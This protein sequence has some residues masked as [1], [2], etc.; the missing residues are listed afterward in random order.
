ML[1]VLKVLDVLLEQR[2]KVCRHHPVEVDP[3]VGVGEREKTFDPKMVRESANINYKSS[4]SEAV[5]Q[6]LTFFS[7]LYSKEQCT[8]MVLFL[9]QWVSVKTFHIQEFRDRK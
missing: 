2:K 4:I 3:H 9:L 6:F 1:R 7:K 8:R 5:T